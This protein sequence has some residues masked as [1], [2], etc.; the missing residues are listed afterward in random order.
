MEPT[1]SSEALEPRENGRPA[2]FFRL[3]GAVLQRSATSTA[4]WFALRLVH[5][6]QRA[7]GLGLAALGRALA[8][9]PL[10]DTRWASQATWASLAGCSE[11]RLLTLAEEWWEAIEPQWNPAGLRLIREA[12]RQGWEVVLL[13]DHP[14]DLL[15]PLLAHTGASRLIAPTLQRDPKHPYK[16]SGQLSA[17]PLTALDRA[18]LLRLA[19]SA[20]QHLAY[21]STRADLPLLA[22]ADKPCAVS[23]DAGLRRHAAALHWPVVEA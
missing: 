19:P 4:A 21:A 14:T 20:P 3:E 17:H 1:L 15:G 22:A 13:A 8:H 7:A 6:R 18:T 10:G 23:P 16:L 2:A 11:D 12:R 5:L 9:S